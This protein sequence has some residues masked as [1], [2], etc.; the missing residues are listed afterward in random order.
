MRESFP[1]TYEASILTRCVITCNRLIMIDMHKPDDALVSISGWGQGIMA[2][3]CMFDC[4]I[5]FFTSY[6]VIAASQL[7]AISR[8]TLDLP[9]RFGDL[10]MGYLRCTIADDQHTPDTSPHLLY[11]DCRSA[12][13]LAWMLGAGSETYHLP[14]RSFRISSC[15]RFFVSLSNPLPVFPHPIWSRTSLSSRTRARTH[16]RRRLRYTKANYL[17]VKIL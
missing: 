5:V 16:T 10:G 17:Y 14:R 15:A 13:I 6:E 4:H 8:G 9:H 12:D 11:C 3:S 7:V 2:H 1:R